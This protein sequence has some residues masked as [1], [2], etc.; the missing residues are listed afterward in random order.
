MGH[1]SI[2]VGI[3]GVHPL[4]EWILLPTLQ[5]HPQAK[6][7]AICGGSAG[8]RA[9]LA[10]LH[11]VPEQYPNLDLMLQFAEL[12]AAIVCDAVPEALP[13]VLDA[14]LHALFLPASFADAET[15]FERCRLRPQQIAMPF[16]P[17]RWL[18]VF[19]A[20]LDYLRDGFIGRPYHAEFQVFIDGE[21]GGSIGAAEPSA[22]LAA[23]WID[24]AQCCFGAVERVH[25]AQAGRAPSSTRLVLGF[26]AGTTAEIAYSRTSQWPGSTPW[27]RA[28][29]HGDNGTLQVDFDTAG[30]ALLR[31]STKADPRL[32]PLSAGPYATGTLM[33]L[34]Q[35]LHREEAGVRLFV[36]AIAGSRQP[37]PD[38]LDAYAVQ[39]VVDAARRSLQSGGWTA[40]ASPAAIRRGA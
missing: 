36:D 31:G 18:P 30:Q 26:A 27:Q 5:T 6:A 33:Q 2:R 23:D 7:V 3:A 1:A 21:A 8:E 25:A 20:L 16:F 11:R 12:D 15:L 17:L 14:G 22:H 32:A 37:Q 10:A 38:W 40:C 9:E 28:R 19:R 13:A 39:C 4:T 34:Q 24:F 29:L 35:A